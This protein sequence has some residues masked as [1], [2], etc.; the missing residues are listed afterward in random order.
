MIVRGFDF[1]L[2]RYATWAVKDADLSSTGAEVEVDVM[3]VDWPV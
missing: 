2:R 1:E 3:H